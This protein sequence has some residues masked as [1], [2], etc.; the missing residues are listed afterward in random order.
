MLLS[1]FCSFPFWLSWLLPFLLGLALGWAIWSKYK[2]LV[3]EKNE[4][5]NQLNQRIEQL[6]YEIDK[7]KSS[8]DDLRTNLIDTKNQIRSLEIELNN[9][10]EAS[11]KM[12]TSLGAIVQNI[13]DNDSAPEKEVD[14]EDKID[15]NND[16]IG[17]IIGA[18]KDDELQI[19]EGIGPKMEQVLK[20]NEISNW[21]EL[22]KNSKEDLRT[23][24]NQYG[25][26]Y[27]IIDVT[28]WQKQAKLAS[29][30]KFM[31]LIELQKNIAGGSTKNT[32]TTQSKLE[33]ILVRKGIIKQYKE[34]DLKA[35]E[36]IG[37]KIEQLLHNAGIKTW[38]ELSKTSSDDIKEILNQAGPRYKLADPSTWP[39]QAKL[40][41]KGNWNELRTYQDFLN[42]GKEK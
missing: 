10:K 42:G 26:K 13:Q 28:T 33:K 20:D 25:D 38:K 19:I 36:G 12:E 5:I 8:E 29:K 15:I 32:G 41:H 30:H 4:S 24:L 40:A 9:C 37:P 21:K 27:K 14:I 35:I 23:L 2:S 3:E 1:T 7:Y 39:K 31:E 16:F 18:L 17:M 6:N 34:N 11:N 22:S